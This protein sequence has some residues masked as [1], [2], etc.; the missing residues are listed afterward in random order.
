MIAFVEERPDFRT[1]LTRYSMALLNQVAQNASCNRLHEVQERCARWLLQSHDRVEGDSFPL[2]HEFLGQMLGVHRPTV[3]IAA[4]I[5]QRAGLIR[6]A[7]GVITVLDRAGFWKRRRAV[8]TG[9]SPANTT[10]CWAQTSRESK[11][12]TCGESAL[13]HSIC[14]DRLIMQ[15][16]GKKFERVVHAWGTYRPT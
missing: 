12:G 8:A 5:L 4:G 11:L 9:S 6:Y 2:T 15:S 14:P 1:V 3:S 7:R 10:G 13:D 16:N